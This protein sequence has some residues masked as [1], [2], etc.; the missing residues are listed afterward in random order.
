MRLSISQIV[1]ISILVLAVSSVAKADSALLLY[2]LNG[3]VTASFYLPVNPVINPFD[4]DI[5]YGFTVIPIDLE[6]NGSP[7]DDYL[8]FYNESQDGGFAAFSNSVTDDFSTEGMQLYSGSED[9]PTMLTT[10]MPISLTDFDTGLDD[11]TLTVVP[12]ATPEPASLFLVVTALI[13]LLAAVM[14]KRGRLL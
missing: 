8:A 3:P 5:G 1:S 13:A 11:Y 2:D 12:I 9:T 7:S 14:T 10:S 6:I 4:A